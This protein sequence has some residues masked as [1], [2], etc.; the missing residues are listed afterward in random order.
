VQTRLRK[1]HHALRFAHPWIDHTTANLD[2]RGLAE[3]LLGSGYYS[4]AMA[5]PQEHS[6]LVDRLDDLL[7]QHLDLLDSYT[8]LRTQLSEQFSSGFFS[9]AGANRNAAASLGAGRRFGEDGFDGRMKAGRM[10]K[11]VAEEGKAEKEEGRCTTAAEDDK[12]VGDATADVIAEAPKDEATLS[13]QLSTMTFSPPTAASSFTI[14]QLQGP[15][16][17]TSPDANDSKP[18]SKPKPHRNPLNWYT[19]LPPPALRQTQQTFVSS[20]DTLTALINATRALDAL[21]DEVR[22]VR[23]ALEGVEGTTG[24]EHD[25]GVEDSSAAGPGAAEGQATELETLKSPATAPRKAQMS[26]R[27]RIKSVGSAKEPPR[28]RVL[29]MQ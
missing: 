20:L 18:A 25:V 7:A 1:Q 21:D 28:S 3:S 26:S 2:T 14:T 22:K 29:K 8:T 19:P 24:G 10:V 9:L 23:A 17:T 5:T 27:S 6:A 12:N 13:A 16:S 4:T 11:I 15:P